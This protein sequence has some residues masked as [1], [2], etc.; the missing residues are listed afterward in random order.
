ME[1]NKLTF[2]F[3]IVPSIICIPSHAAGTSTEISGFLTAGAAYS[4]NE[5]AYLRGGITDEQPN[6]KQDTVLGIQIDSSIDSLTRISA[7]FIASNKEST[8]FDTNA[9]WLYVARNIGN[10]TTFRLGRLRL[11]AF[12]FSQQLFVGASYLW[13]RPPQEVYNQLVSL[14]NFTGGDITFTI[15]NNLGTTSL[16]MY[17]GRV[18][19]KPILLIQNEASLST[20]QLIG[21][22]GRFDTENLSLFLAYTKSD[23]KITLPLPPP[24]PT[25][26]LNNDLSVGTFGLQ[27]NLGDFEL[28]SEYIQFFDSDIESS[29]W[30]S[31]IA[32]HMSSWTPYLTLA[33][34]D[35]SS[36][37]PTTDIAA[38]SGSFGVP[39]AALKVDSESITIGIRKDLSPKVSVN[40]EL[41]NGEAKHGTKGLFTE[42]NPSLSLPVEQ[43]DSDITMF[44]FAIN[45]LF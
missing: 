31:T 41:H 32:Y 40:A 6:Y 13:L 14:T 23:S 11:P 4:D 8:N 26:V 45:I 27:Y 5:T 42:F 10:Y 2:L 38:L 9:E 44:S 20:D 12:M 19:D 29:G 36:I 22:V 18:D 16:Q 7:Q 43:K 37:D 33:Q 15:D 25:M 39:F 17:T 34:A 24:F 35:S 30:Y 1:L 21:A 28:L 3:L